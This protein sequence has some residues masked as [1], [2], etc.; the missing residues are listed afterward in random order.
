MT[1]NAKNLVKAWIH[2]LDPSILV[3]ILKESSFSSWFLSLKLVLAVLHPS[4]PKLLLLSLLCLGFR[5]P[6]GQDCVFS[7]QQKRVLTIVSR[8]GLLISPFDREVHHCNEFFSH[9]KDDGF[10]CSEI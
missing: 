7:L 2:S 3:I 4:C 1:I 10:H 9:Y 5:A 6:T 8:L